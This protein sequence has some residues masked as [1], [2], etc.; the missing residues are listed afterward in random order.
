MNTIVFLV[1][2]LYN[3]DMATGLR[4]PTEF[5]TAQFVTS[6]ESLKECNDIRNRMMVKNP[7][8]KRRV[9]CFQVVADPLEDAGKLF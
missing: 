7:D 4:E 1:I 5:P 6:F 2:W 9:A 3:V 8:Y